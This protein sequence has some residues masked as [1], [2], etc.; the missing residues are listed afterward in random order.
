MP[1]AAAVAIIDKSL[2]ELHPTLIA[3]EKVETCHRLEPHQRE[4]DIRLDCIPVRQDVTHDEVR[5]RHHFL[6][7]ELE[8]LLARE[9]LRDPVVD[10]LDTAEVL[11]PEDRHVGEHRKGIDRWRGGFRRKHVRVADPHPRLL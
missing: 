7:E 10:A 4:R 5:L 8:H 6:S 3:P 9:W 11:V 1:Y 2:V